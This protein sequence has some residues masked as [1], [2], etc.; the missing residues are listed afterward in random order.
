MGSVVKILGI[1]CEDTMTV[2]SVEKA[3]FVDGICRLKYHDMTLPKTVLDGAQIP[4]LNSAS[5]N[6]P[7]RQVLRTQ[8]GTYHK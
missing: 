6:T 1:T 7:S 5:I 2:C 8:V 3:S 4:Y